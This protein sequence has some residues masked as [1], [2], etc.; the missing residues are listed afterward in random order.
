MPREQR[1]TSRRRAPNHARPGSTCSRPPASSRA[2]R[3]PGSSRPPT[4]HPPPTGS[5]S[6]W[7]RTTRRAIIE[8]GLTTA[9]IDAPTGLQ[10]FK[11]IAPNFD[12]GVIGRGAGLR[13][14]RHRC[15]RRARPRDGR[16]CLQ[17]LGRRDQPRSAVRGRRTHGRV[18]QGRPRGR[19]ERRPLAV[20]ADGTPGTM[21]PRLA[22][23]QRFLATPQRAYDSRTTAPESSARAPATLATRAHP[24]RG[25]TPGVPRMRSAS[26]ATSRSP[27]RTR[28]AS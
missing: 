7:P 11:V 13:R 9:G 21:D 6:S 10:A 8:T 12:Y 18:V 27:R 16:R 15:G 3:W 23:R 1:T 2:P 24:D 28:V 20:L 22:R 5:R 14:R 25:V 19:R 26:S 4:L 17:R